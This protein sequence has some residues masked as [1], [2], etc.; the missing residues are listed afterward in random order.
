MKRD[1][2]Q[3]SH[4]FVR[5]DWSNEGLSSPMILQKCCY[6]LDILTWNLASPVKR[7]S[8]VGSL[9]HYRLESVGPEIPLRN[10]D[11]CSIEP[12]CS[13]SA[14]SSFSNMVQD[15]GG[16]VECSWAFCRLE[17]GFGEL[18]S[19]TK[20][21]FFSSSLPYFLAMVLIKENYFDV[22]TA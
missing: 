6:D 14:Y 3:R 19:I 11:G 20:A 4:S 12:N 5:A 22:P 1:V 10:T 7:L 13:V 9:L 15:I 21:L 16:V 18:Y 17:C 2:D 8:S